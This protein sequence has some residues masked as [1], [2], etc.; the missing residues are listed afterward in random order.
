MKIG[1]LVLR[2]YGEFPKKDYPQYFISSMLRK[3]RTVSD[4][5][6]FCKHSRFA[7]FASA[8][9][10]EVH[11]NTFWTD[12]LYKFLIKELDFHFTEWNF[13]LDLLIHIKG[14]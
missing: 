8:I 2:I 11:I 5:E 12:A 13:I 7:F 6:P 3:L 9:T 1:T 4:E 10:F 14:E